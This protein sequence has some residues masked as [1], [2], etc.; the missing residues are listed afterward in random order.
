[1]AITTNDVKL[2]FYAKKLGVSF[3]QTI[4]LGR[5]KLYASHD[6]IKESIDHFKNNLK[7]L[8]EVPFTDE[9]SE[10][11]FKILGAVHIDSLDVSNYEKATLIYDMNHP[12]PESLLKKYSVVVDGGTL[13]HIFNFPQAITNAMNLVKTGGHFIGISPVNNLM[14]HGFYQFSP[15][16]YHR[17][18]GRENGFAI[19]KMIIVSVDT[20]GNYGDWYEVADP[21][22]VK[23]RSVLMNQFPTYLMSIA[24]KS[25]DEIKWLVISI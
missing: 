1:M 3:E 4:M 8:E 7:S 14:G 20:N 22:A 17:V 9:Y 5:L 13:E 23:T 12:L 2:L 24:E 18:F 19:K 25:A 16:L 21:R 10:P 15:E 6:V 11:L